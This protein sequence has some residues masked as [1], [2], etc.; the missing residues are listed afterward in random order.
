MSLL[1]TVPNLHMSSPIPAPTRLSPRS[2][3]A[4]NEPVLVSII[5]TSCEIMY[6]NVSASLIQG[7]QKDIRT[8]ILGIS[9]T[10]NYRNTRK[11]KKYKKK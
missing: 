6:V 1:T 10:P 3:V 8:E 7:V 4:P 5:D 2:G 11:T 9:G